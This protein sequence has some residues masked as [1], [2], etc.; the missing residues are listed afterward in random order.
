MRR[1]WLLTSALLALGACAA[2]PIA[3][4]APQAQRAC[5][6]SSQVTGFADAGPDRALVHIGT[7]ETWELTLSPGCPDVDWAMKLGVR[8]RGGERICPG[9]PAEL[10]VPN[11]SESG[12]RRCLVRN[13]RR[14]SADEAAAARGI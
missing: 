4:T 6:W 14:L 1:I 10:L 3:G 2:P 5:F 11:A 12:F 13:V 7:R 9:R 8:A